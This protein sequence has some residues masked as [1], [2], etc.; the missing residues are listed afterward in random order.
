M[1]DQPTISDFEFD[2]KLKQLQEL[3]AQHAEYFDANSPTQRVGGTIT[4]NFETVAHENRMYS[5][6]NSYSRE[7]LIDWEVKIQKM[8]GNVSLDYTCEL[9][10]DGASIS[11]TYENGKLKP[12][13]QAERVFDHGH[14]VCVLENGDL[15]VCQWN[16][17]QTYPIKLE[18]V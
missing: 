13:M 10:Y 17:F 14:D 7:D 15:I 6:D 2:Q 1:L 9:K 16:A 18:R 8:L 4:K 5:L 3:E 11:I 12:L